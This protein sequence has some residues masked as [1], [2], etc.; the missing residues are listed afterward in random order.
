MRYQ[1]TAPLNNFVSRCKTRDRNGFPAALLTSSDPALLKDAVDELVNKLKATNVVEQNFL[2]LRLKNTQDFKAEFQ[3]MVYTLNLN[4]GFYN[5]YR[6]IVAVDLSEWDREAQ[7]EELDA[8]L[9]YLYDTGENGRRIYIFYAAIQRTDPLRRMIKNY[10]VAEE[11]ILKMEKPM[12]IYNYTIGLLTDRYGVQVEESGTT[13][14]YK[15]IAAMAKD[16]TFAGVSSIHNYCRDLVS[17]IDG[18]LN[19][20][21]ISIFQRKQSKHKQSKSKNDIGLIK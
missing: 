13:G 2:N 16:D 4:A 1:I 20:A 18:T 3:R 10:F 5:S 9:A 21:S 17:E 6:G 7:C 14:L 15:S 8:A 12:Q 11:A 19:A